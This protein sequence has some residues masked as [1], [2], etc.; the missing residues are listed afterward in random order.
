M[1]G[2][3][4]Q[5]EFL[6]SAPPTSSSPSSRGV[7]PARLLLLL[8]LYAFV[9]GRAIYLAT[10]PRIPCAPAGRQSRAHLLRVR[11]HQR[12]MVTGL[13]PVVGVPLPW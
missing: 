13:L 3:Q 6:P 4:A 11:V 2:S 9:V 5:L 12:G 7:R 8:L 1:N 10:R